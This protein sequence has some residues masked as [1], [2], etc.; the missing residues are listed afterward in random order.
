MEASVC[1]QLI[2]T[3]PTRVRKLSNPFRYL[4]PR[5]R[6]EQDHLA[7]FVG[8]LPESGRLRDKRQDV[9]VIYK[10]WC[11][12]N[13]AKMKPDQMMSMVKLKATDMKE[14][15]DVE[16][17]PRSVTYTRTGLQWTINFF[18]TPC[19]NTNNAKTR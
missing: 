9:H 12:L 5:Y 8:E 3:L 10:D 14:P 11:K 15:V 6:E 4:L 7:A 1:D 13:L 2:A 19:C 16:N 18:Y 17:V